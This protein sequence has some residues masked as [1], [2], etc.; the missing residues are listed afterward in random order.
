MVS[1]PERKL[2]VL[3]CGYGHLGL[4]LLQGLWGCAHDCE[5]VGVFRW[6]ARPGS[7]QF[8]E[9]VESVFQKQVEQCGLRDIACKGMN[10]YEFTA[11]IKELQPDVVLVGSWGEIIK[12]HLIEHPG[13]IL[14][15]CHPSKLPAHRGANPYS[16][17][18]RERAQETGVT[19]HRMAPQIDAG[20]ILLQKAIPLGLDENGETVR[21]KCMTVAY[22]L[23]PEL[24]RRLKA[25]VVYGEPLEEQPQDETQQSYFSQLKPEH[26]AIRW[27]DSAES[28]CRQMRAL[29][30]WI[31]CYGQLSPKL[32]VM[33]YDPNFVAVAPESQQSHPPGLIISAKK[34]RLRIALSDPGQVLEVSLYQFASGN[35]GVPPWLNGVFSLFWLR[36]GQRFISLPHK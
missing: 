8:W 7:A 36:P 9:P 30:P 13:I 33:F 3:L 12:R 27:E 25:H 32:R 31:A 6:T 10:S 18:I 35:H 14:I 21:D 23:V 19:F 17:V 29:F 4:A 16:S 20:A 1:N 22:E 2:R 34:G 24:V 5:I 15:N 28:I 26:G 11:L